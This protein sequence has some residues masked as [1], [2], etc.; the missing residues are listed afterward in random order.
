[1][2]LKNPAGKGSKPNSRLG[3]LYTNHL[4]HHASR[5]TLSHMHHRIIDKLTL[6]PRS[7]ADPG[8]PGGPVSPW[9]QTTP[10]AW[11]SF[12]KHEQLYRN[13]KLS[14]NKGSVKYVPEHRG[15]YG[16][17]RVLYTGMHACPQH[18]FSSLPQ[19]FTGNSWYTWMEKSSLK[20]KHL[21]LK[22]NILLG[23]NLGCN[24]QL[25]IG[26]SLLPILNPLDAITNG[27]TN[28]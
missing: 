7:P 3:V 24:L 11:S 26:S 14:P 17:S 22:C 4:I 18:N 28:L 25:K 6:I 8:G 1:M 15:K 13:K 19:H 2:P 12:R 5:L 20:V 21:A 27:L 23:P 10:S 16:R 9:K